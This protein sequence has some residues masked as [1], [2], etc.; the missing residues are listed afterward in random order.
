MLLPIDERT[1][2]LSLT[3][4]LTTRRHIAPNKLFIDLLLSVFQSTA[5]ET[6]V[7]RFL[8]SYPRPL[9]LKHS[10][11]S[12]V[13]YS[14]LLIFIF[15]IKHELFPSNKSIINTSYYLLKI[16]KVVHNLFNF[17]VTK[18]PLCRRFFK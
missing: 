2:R 5:G 15:P 16:S 18:T 6:I 3:F 17:N 9:A 12:L 7:F 14:A 1:P 4:A 11:Y 8:N 10:N 13:Y